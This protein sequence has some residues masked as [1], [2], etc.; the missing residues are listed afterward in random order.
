[1]EGDSTTCSQVGFRQMLNLM[2]NA[3]ALEEVLDLAKALDVS[4]V[5]VKKTANSAADLLAKEGVSCQCLW[6]DQISPMCI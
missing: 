1:M 4:F 3:N 5:H 6:I 2:K